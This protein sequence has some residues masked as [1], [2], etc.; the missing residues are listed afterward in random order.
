MGYYGS[1]RRE[2]ISHIDQ[3]Q[4]RDDKEAKHS[5]E[6]GLT[7]AQIDSLLYVHGCSEERTYSLKLLQ[8]SPLF[9]SG[10][11]D[12]L[13]PTLQ[14]A[15]TLG[16]DMSEDPYELFLLIV[17]DHLGVSKSELIKREEKDRKKN[18]RSNPVS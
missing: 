1:D 3:Q 11:Y 7:K 10:I 9:L 17:A 14:M 18:D 2:P 15:V 13:R 5:I 4:H 6:S 8:S 12:C 16:V